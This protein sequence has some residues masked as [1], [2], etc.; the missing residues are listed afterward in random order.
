MHPHVLP[1]HSPI[2]RLLDCSHVAAIANNDVMNKSMP[3]TLETL[4]STLAVAGSPQRGRCC[5]VQNKNLQY[6]HTTLKCHLK[7]QQFCC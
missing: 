1:I 4:F 6:C 5:G 7:S 2:D 3:I